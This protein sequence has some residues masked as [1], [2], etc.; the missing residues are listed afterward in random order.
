MLPNIQG[1]TIM[2][3]DIDD[4]DISLPDRS[5]PCG[6][7]NDDRAVSSVLVG[8]YH[9]M[10]AHPNWFTKTQDRQGVPTEERVLPDP[11]YKP[12][13]WGYVQDDWY[14]AWLVWRSGSW[15]LGRKINCA[16]YNDEKLDEKQRMKRSKPRQTMKCHWYTISN[17]ENSNVIDADED[18]IAATEEAASTLVNLTLPGA[19]TFESRKKR[20]EAQAEAREKLEKAIAAD[21]GWE[22]CRD[23]FAT[24]AGDSSVMD[25]TS[26]KDGSSVSHSDTAKM[27]YSQA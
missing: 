6:G 4:L 9:I 19:A 20:R 10:E 26:G 18:A 12:G 17:L 3:D 5:Y 2:Q 21:K 24:L 22:E 27:L 13:L 7:E 15:H 11:A 1:F 14:C 16:W 23:L 25:M 8:L